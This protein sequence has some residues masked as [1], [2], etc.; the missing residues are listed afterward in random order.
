MG[1]L[2]A[3]M[4]VEFMIRFLLDWKNKYE[5]WRGERYVV[6]RTEDSN[7]NSLVTVAVDDLLAE[8]GNRLSD[9][10]KTKEG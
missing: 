8:P 10:W 1:S 7:D 3:I 9:W 5:C 2:E 6:E 4:I